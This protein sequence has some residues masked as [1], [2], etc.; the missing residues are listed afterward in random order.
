VTTAAVT[1]AYDRNG[2]PAPTPLVA[3]PSA[4]ATRLR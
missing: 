4:G 2:F 1:A 3:V